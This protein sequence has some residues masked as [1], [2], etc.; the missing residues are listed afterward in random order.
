MHQ[1]ADFNMTL[2]VKVIPMYAS[3]TLLAKL[4]THETAQHV[5]RHYHN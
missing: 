5:P 3:T 1:Q 2:A 4:T